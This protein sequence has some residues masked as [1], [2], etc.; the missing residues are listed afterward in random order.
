MHY[1]LN[2]SINNQH[3]LELKWYYALQRICAQKIIKLSA[4]F[5][6]SVF[7]FILNIGTT[8]L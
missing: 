2:L 5:G 1:A 4:Y 3:S 8:N 6:T 7:S